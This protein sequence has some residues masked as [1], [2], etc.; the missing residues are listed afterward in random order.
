MAATTCSRS[1]PR[2]RLAED[3]GAGAGLVAALRRGDDPPTWIVTGTE[4]AAVRRAAS[5]LD[6]RVLRDRYAVAQPPGGDPLALPL[7]DEGGG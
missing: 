6:E 4:Q 2:G 3:L 1:T 5:L 7:I